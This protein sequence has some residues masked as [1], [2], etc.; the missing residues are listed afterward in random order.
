MTKGKA[1]IANREKER[2]NK[3]DQK[4]NKHNDHP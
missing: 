3:L 4:K 1:V 2:K